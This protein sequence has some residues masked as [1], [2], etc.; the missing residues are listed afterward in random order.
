MDTMR[1]NLLGAL[2]YFGINGISVPDKSSMR[3]LAMRAGTW[4]S[5][6]EQALLHNCESDVIATKELL[7]VIENKLDLPR[8]LQRGR[9]TKAVA[10]MEWNGVPIDVEALHLLREHWA[11]IHEE[12]ISRVDSNYGVYHGRTFKTEKWERWVLAHAIPWP[13]LESGRLALDNETFKS[14]SRAY[15]AVRPI[16][17][18]RRAIGN[19]DSN[20]CA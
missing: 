10:Q 11:N 1:D 20:L 16:Y 17:E 9:Y 19:W 5:E 2:T 6:E 12:L 18:L 8:A 13:R 4:S 3:E 14:I 15:P 7:Q